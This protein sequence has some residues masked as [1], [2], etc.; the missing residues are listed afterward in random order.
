[1]SFIKFMEGM[2]MANW[3]QL[4]GGGFAHMDAP[5]AVHPSDKQ[6]A[7]LYR[8]EA[9]AANLDWP[10]VEGHVDGYADKKG[11]TNDK[12]AEEKKRVRIFMKM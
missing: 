12:R 3:E 7:K 11:W 8:D 6:R 10:A 4:I 5:F 9:K 1:M 2:E